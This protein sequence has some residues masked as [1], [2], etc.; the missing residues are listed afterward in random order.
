MNKAPVKEEVTTWDEVFLATGFRP[1]DPKK[2]EPMYIEEIYRKV[3]SFP[4]SIVK[5]KGGGIPGTNIIPGGSSIMI[6][7]RDRYVLKMFN[8]DCEGRVT[9]TK[10]WRLA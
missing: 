10:S 4:F 6:I 2:E 5:I 8:S 1:E 9:D 3:G 7:S